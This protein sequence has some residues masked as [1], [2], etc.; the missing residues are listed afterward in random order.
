MEYKH[1]P[2]TIYGKAGCSYCIMAK[3][4]LE[5][6]RIP[7]EYRE[8]ERDQLLELVETVNEN[9]GVRPKSVPIVYHGS[10]FIGGFNELKNSL[11]S[12]MVFLREG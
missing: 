7:F 3:T 10:R 11:D 2:Y 4:L 1:T 9:F 12:Q 5:S 8:M 6:R